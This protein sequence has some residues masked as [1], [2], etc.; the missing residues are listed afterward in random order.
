M[1]AFA[2]LW[3]RTK[4]SISRKRRNEV[5]SI[6]C[7]HAIPFSFPPLSRLTAWSNDQ[8]IL[9][10]TKSSWTWR[11]KMYGKTSLDKQDNLKCFCSISRKHFSFFLSVLAHLVFYS[12]FNDTR[13]T[14]SPKVTAKKCQAHWIAFTERAKRVH[15]IKR[16]EWEKRGFPSIIIVFWNKRLFM[17]LSSSIVEIVCR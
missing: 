5:F 1:N 10:N 14:S 6:H 16:T 8:D 11:R 2:K 3:T 4:E 12:A 15:T 7:F 17:R 13:S 9:F